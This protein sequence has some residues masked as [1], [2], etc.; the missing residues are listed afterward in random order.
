[1]LD[2][3]SLFTATDPGPP[4]SPA[5]QP[6]EPRVGLP[7]LRVQAGDG[8]LLAPGSCHVS[9]ALP[10]MMHGGGSRLW[11]KSQPR[12]LSRSPGGT[13]LTSQGVR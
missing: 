13:V 5:L 7:L 8:V 6:P 3:P 9:S 10:L 12:K 2:D 4:Q 11:G 1:M